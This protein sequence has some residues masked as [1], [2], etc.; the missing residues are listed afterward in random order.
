MGSNSFGNIFRITTFGESHGK[1]IGVVI[2]GCP[3]KI[4]IT[5]DDIDFEL[6]KRK[7][8]KYPF[9]SPRNEKDKAKII[10]GV[11]EGKTTG[12]PITIIIENTKAISKPYDD[13]K[14]LYRPSHGN[15]TYLQ[16]Y[17]IF[18]YA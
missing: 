2:D 16:K 18:D 9:T 12:C 1:S 10:S 13:I 17:G 11:F 15:F 5:E 4:E 6:E 3:S 8:S 14:N 7:P